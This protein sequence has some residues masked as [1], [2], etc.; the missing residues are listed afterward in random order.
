MISNKQ[1]CPENQEWTFHNPQSTILKLKLK[2]KTKITIPKAQIQKH[3][4]LVHYNPH[5]YTGVHKLNPN[6]GLSTI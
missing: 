4:H 3:E 5:V 6:I 2:K 1:V